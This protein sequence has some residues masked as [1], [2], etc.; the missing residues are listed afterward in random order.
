MYE[1][2]PTDLTKLRYVLYARKSTEDENRQVRSINDQIKDCRNLAKNL[3]L[4][5][6]AEVTEQKSAK[7]PNHRPKFTQMLKDISSKKYDA[8]L[9]WHPDRLCRNMLEGGQIINMLDENVL[10]D[11]RFHSHQFSN[12]ANG[13]MLLG[14]LFVFSKQY[15]DDLSAKVSRGVRGNFSEG[16]SSGSPKF[17]YDRNEDTGHYEPNEYFD[18]VKEVWDLRE[19]GASYAQSAK[20]LVDRGYKRVVGSGKNHRIIKPTSGSMAKMFRDPFYFG[21]LTQANQE[22]DLREVYNFT[23]MISEESYKN[24]QLISRSRTRDIYPK[25]RMTF[26][27]LRGLVYC[28]ICNSTKYMSPGKNKSH[29]GTYYLT[30]RCNNLECNRKPRSF[31]AKHVFN[32]LYEV[33]DNIELTDKTYERY[34][35]RLGSMTDAKIIEIKQDIRSKNVILTNIKSEIESRSLGIIDYDKD[36]TIFKTNDSKITQL[37]FEQ[38]EIE[39]DLTRLKNQVKNPQSIKVSKSEFLNL[40]KTASDKMKAGSPV[41]KD[42]L[43]QILF[44]NLRV[45][46]EKVLSHIWK[47]PFDELVKIIDSNSGGDER[48]RTSKLLGTC[49]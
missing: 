40:V 23:P 39:R 29:T 31:R 25:K 26:Y 35:R 38:R 45:G 28:G 3:G 16:K 18:L 14:M 33:L 42:A 44:L 15:S 1:E 19:A 46:N 4:K 41:E 10:L 49:S 7:K 8:I 24:V 21:I 17:G 30:Y 34:S 6:V 11:I 5:V 37:T 47:E 32:Y 20:K 43:A 36:S 12:D 9:C 13:K 27:P 48:T 2:P 22:V